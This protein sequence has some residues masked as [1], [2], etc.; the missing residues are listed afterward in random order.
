MQ[1]QNKFKWSSRSAF[2]VSR[3]DPA[4][5]AGN[6]GHNAIELILQQSTT[7]DTRQYENEDLPDVGDI[8]GHV[9]LGSGVEI[10]FGSQNWRFDAA[11][12][13]PG[14]EDHCNDRVDNNKQ[15]GPV[16]KPWLY[17]MF[18]LRNTRHDIF[19]R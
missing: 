18:N 7:A 1:Y 2:V 5:S 10:R 12:P 15:R 11:Q 4:Q 9:V 8:G 3:E 17:S 16:T 14:Q 13:L 19:A 6:A